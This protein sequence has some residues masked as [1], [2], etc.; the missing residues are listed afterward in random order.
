MGRLKSSINK[1]KNPS[2]S[3]FSHSSS[4]FPK[5]MAACDRGRR[6]H[7][8]A[9]DPNPSYPDFTK[10]QCIALPGII[11]FN[12]P[13]AFNTL[14]RDLDP[15]KSGY[16]DLFEKNRGLGFEPN[17]VR[18]TIVVSA[19]ARLLDLEMGKRIDENW[20][21]ILTKLNA[22]VEASR[23]G[24][25]FKIS[26]GNTSFTTE[27]RAGTATFLTMA[28]IL[29]VNASILDLHHHRLHT[30]RR[31]FEGIGSNLGRFEGIGSYLGLISWGRTSAFFTNILGPK[32]RR[33]FEGIGE[34]GDRR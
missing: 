31:R 9:V 4:L 26:E 29:T 32:G 10:W 27:I 5:S 14:G 20:I 22:Y 1:N 24:K 2:T 17:S 16:V 8:I 34:I 23:V 19:C 25:R 13:Q 28:Y 3:L 6:N 11:Q 21:S 18:L 33:R 15:L 7:Q 12:A 30:S